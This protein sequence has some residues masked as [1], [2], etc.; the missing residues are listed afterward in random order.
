MPGGCLIPG[1]L[2]AAILVAFALFSTPLPAV[3]W[4]ERLDGHG[5]PIKSVAIT[6]DGTLALSSSFDYSAI[7]WR[8]SDDTA[9]VGLRL[10]GHEAAVNDARFVDGG[11]IA[12]VSD[13]GSVAL[14]DGR[15]G[16]M[17]GRIDEGEEKM[18]SLA[19][20]ADG[21]QV[22]AASWDRNAYVYDVA[23]GQ[24]RPAAVLGGHRSNV[25]A[26]L[27]LPDG[28]G[29][30][31]ASYDGGIRLFD[32]R[33]GELKREV[34]SH[35]W[36]INVFSLMPDGDSIVFG[37]ADGAVGVLS[38]ASGGTIK[39]LPEHER[40]VLSMALSAD[41]AVLAEG[42]GDGLIRYYSVADWALE[43][44]FQNPYGPVWGMAIAPD[45]STVLYAGLD[46]HVNTW[47][48]KPRQP[49]EPVENTFPRRFQV[50]D[51]EDAGE[52][53]FARKCSVCHTL[54]RDGE[55]RAGPS[56]YG[57]F[58]RKVGS[59][60]GYPYSEALRRADFVWSETK[61]AELFDYGPDVVTPGSKMPIQRLKSVADRDALIA[62]L[63]RSTGPV[64]RSGNA[65][66][67]AKD[68]VVK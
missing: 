27:F 46:D 35:G 38:L 64:S 63:K 1:R 30:L 15:S 6:P 56:L 17:L 50:S 26:A 58:G 4:P 54:T 37:G 22:V 61:I 24:L 66:A 23:G 53:Q 40:P 65:D 48:V 42:G 55:Y 36:G 32:R 29:I 33:T 3:A 9:E 28:T 59:L 57:I 68:E 67:N 14:W 31:T 34:Y 25:N 43:E 21:R 41:G 52:L 12:T 62:F 13:D 19:V 5:G 10:I 2:P 11:N 8:V 44:E 45:N 18:L 47:L 39:V 51:T 16:S 60:D 49:F 7:L 20:S